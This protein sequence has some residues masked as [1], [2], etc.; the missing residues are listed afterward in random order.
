MKTSQ[1]SLRELGVGLIL[2]FVVAIESVRRTTTISSVTVMDRMFRKRP[3]AYVEFTNVVHPSSCAVGIRLLYWMASPNMSWDIMTSVVHPYFES[4]RR[5][6]GSW[7][8]GYE[9]YKDRVPRTLNFM[10]PELIPI[11]ELIGK[12][13]GD[14]RSQWGALHEEF[15][16]CERLLEISFNNR[17]VFHFWLGFFILQGNFTTDQLHAAVSNN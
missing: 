1:C 16:E 7:V 10:S 12:Y 15:W 6:P 4:I 5:L 3:S 11:G 14:P 8:P 9:M 17:A 2:V 13:F